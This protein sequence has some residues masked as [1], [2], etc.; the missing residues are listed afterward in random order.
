MKQEF[1]C[2][3]CPV[4]CTLT[5]VEEDHQIMVTGNQ[6]KRG[7]EFGEKEYTRPMR[8]LTTTVKIEGS[9]HKRL[10][11]ISEGEIPKEQLHQCLQAL[12]ELSIKAPIKRGDIVVEDICHT[13]VNIVASRGIEPLDND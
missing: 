10:P 11:V 12:Y 8:I 6:C 9:L 5:V 7:L 1:T 3:V 4:G 13:G 2:I